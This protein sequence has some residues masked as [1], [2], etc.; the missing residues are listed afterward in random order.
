MQA[1]EGNSRRRLK[2]GGSQDWLPHKLPAQGFH[3]GRGGG[4]QAAQGV[5]AFQHRNDAAAG[6]PVGNLHH[7]SGEVGEVAVGQSEAAQQIAGARVEAGRDQDEVGPELLR[8]RS[9]PVLDRA[10][11]FLAARPRRKRNFSART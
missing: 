4:R 7:E 2:A 9:K 5:A 11:D 3:V 1:G 10:Q 6:V 8:Y